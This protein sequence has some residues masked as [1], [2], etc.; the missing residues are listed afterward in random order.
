VSLDQNSCYYGAS[1]NPLFVCDCETY[2]GSVC[3]VHPKSLRKGKGQG[4]EKKKDPDASSI[5]KNPPKKEEEGTS[6]LEGGWELLLEKGMFK[7]KNC[8]L[9]QG[10]GGE[11]RPARLLQ[12]ECLA[13]RRGTIVKGFQQRRSCW[14]RFY[15]GYLKSKKRLVSLGKEVNCAA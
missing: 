1:K 3:S 15:R 14:E 11:E 9:G 2:E 5:K 12:G 10:D 13:P 7:E 4:R 8:G 6:V